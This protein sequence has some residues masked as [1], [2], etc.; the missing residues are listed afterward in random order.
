MKD[1]IDEFVATFKYPP[2]AGFILHTYANPVWRDVKVLGADRQWL[3]PKMLLEVESLS[4]LA[5]KS[6]QDYLYYLLRY[7]AWNQDKQNP[8][9]IKRSCRYRFVR[10]LRRGEAA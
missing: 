1:C 4:H 5:P 10:K 8:A 9:F 7:F 3:S 2:K 6:R